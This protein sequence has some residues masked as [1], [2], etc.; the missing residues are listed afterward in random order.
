MTWRERW[1]KATSAVLAVTRPSEEEE[2][3]IRGGGRREQL[4][5]SCT[6]SSAQLSSVLDM[7]QAR[8]DQWQDGQAAAG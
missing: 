4:L 8:R 6:V 7:L 3:R 1:R 2:R 5:S